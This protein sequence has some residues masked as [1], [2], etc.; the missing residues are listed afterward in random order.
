[1]NPN[2]YSDREEMKAQLDLLH[3]KLDKQTIVSDRLVRDVV[4]SKA[5]SINRDALIIT[6]VAILAIPYCVWL[7]ISLQVD[8]AFTI[9]TAIFF[10]VAVIYN[11]YSHRGFQSSQLVGCSLAEIGR[12][13][14][15]MKMLQA[16]WLRFSIPFL[17]VWISWFAYEI[18]TQAGVSREECMGILIG[19]A[20]GGVLGGIAGVV[21]Y[22]R[23]QRLAAEIIEQVG[24]GE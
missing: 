20:V 12:R 5:D 15:R 11:I 17:I 6:I 2:E 24:E 10:I 8:L 19:G 14:V 9:V 4:R 22:R 3:Q 7:F 16:R 23:S 13:T 21:A 1:M 18:L